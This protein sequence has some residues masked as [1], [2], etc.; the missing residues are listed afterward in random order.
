MLGHSDFCVQYI[1]RIW[2]IRILGDRMCG[3]C[4]SVHTS[5]LFWLM[6]HNHTS[7][8]TLH[9]SYIALSWYPAGYWTSKSILPANSYKSKQ[10][11]SSAGPHLCW[12]QRSQSYPLIDI[13]IDDFNLS[14]CHPDC[15]TWI[16]GLEDLGFASIKLEVK[17]FCFFLD[18]CQSMNEHIQHFWVVLRI[19]I[20]RWYST[21]TCLV[22]LP[23]VMTV[24]Y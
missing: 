16:T 13:W 18:S 3:M 7:R 15:W 19:C 24:L 17:R 1:M 6:F 14:L 20:H 4:R 9:R 21:T 12:H 23:L 10:C 2:I 11:L 5:T 22:C 8:L